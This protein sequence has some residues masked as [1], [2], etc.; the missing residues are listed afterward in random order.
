MPLYKLNIPNK[1]LNSGVLERAKHEDIDYEKYFEAWLENSPD[2][3]LDDEGTVIWIGRQVKADI[4]EIGKYP[5]LIG[6]D[7]EGNLVI[8]ELKK[9]RTPREVVAQILEYSSWASTLDYD[10]LNEIACDYFRRQNRDYQS[11]REAHRE[12]FFPDA[13]EFPDIEFNGSQKLFI[14]AEEVSPIIRQVTAHLRTKYRMGIFC[15]EY[16]V[17]R[18]EQGEY[19]ISTERIGGS[20]DLGIAGPKQAASPTRWNEAVKVKDA[21]YETVKQ[22]TKEDNTVTFTPADIYNEMVKTY[23]AVNRNTVG[24]QLIQDCV[25]HTSRKHYPSGQQDLYFQP[26]KGNSVFTLSC[27]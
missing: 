20:E 23:P 5:D 7:S 8:V 15:L 4:G 11:L 27:G 24:C 21:I 1:N 19:F 25:N 17:L 18:T 16:E 2:A 3:L 14:T 22:V 10:Q 9:G 13:E 26:E 12:V 6:I